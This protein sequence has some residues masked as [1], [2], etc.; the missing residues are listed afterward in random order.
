MKKL[1][2][3]TIFNIEI[4]TYLIASLTISVALLGG[5][6]LMKTENVGFALCILIPLLLGILWT[7]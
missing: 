6:Y 5:L 1:L 3:K 7:E 4:K 2:K